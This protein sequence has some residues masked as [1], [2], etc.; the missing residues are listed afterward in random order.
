MVASIEVLG[1][2][3]TGS[4]LSFK[5]CDTGVPVALANVQWC[6]LYVFVTILIL[7]L[8]LFE[9]ANMRRLQPSKDGQGIRGE[10]KGRL[11]DREIREGPERGGKK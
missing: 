11:R 3:A 9:Y 2:D 5:R 6:K 8:L 10:A 4:A 1:S 7:E